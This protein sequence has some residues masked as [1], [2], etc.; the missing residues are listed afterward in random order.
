MSSKIVVPPTK[1][2][3]LSPAAQQAPAQKPASNAKPGATLAEIA[4]QAQQPASIGK[5]PEAPKPKSGDAT[6]AGVP[7][8]SPA[9]KPEPTAP[10]AG[11]KEPASPP[12]Q[13]PPVSQGKLEEKPE[14]D[15]QFLYA[16]RAEGK[17]I[18]VTTPAGQRYRGL[19]KRFGRYTVELQT[20]AGPLVL[21]KTSLQ[22]LQLAD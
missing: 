15:T 18:A 12:T 8:G 7:S 2:G 10:P 9:A 3:P 20:E 17:A 4:R 1:P 5:P 21:Y 19:V 6:P 22:S 13:Q 11:K 16:A 14:P